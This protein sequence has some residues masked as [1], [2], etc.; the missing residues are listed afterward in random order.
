[1][2]DRQA[3]QDYLLWL[4]GFVCPISVRERYT[5][6]LSALTERSFTAKV[7]HDDNR[8]SD[9][10]NLRFRFAELNGIHP[11]FWIG[12]LP[13]ECLVLEM[14]IALSIRMEDEFLH[15]PELGN[16]TSVWFWEL[17]KNV[18]LDDQ[19]DLNY[20]EDY[21]QMRINIIV[22]RTYDHNGVGGLFP[23]KYHRGDMRRTE[24]W[25]QM[26]YYISEKLADG[27]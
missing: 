9:G 2:N 8:E 11:D 10:Q 16:R 20:D 18:G 14:L 21:V 27:S 12:I 3:V 25:Y 24:L 1:M 22:D 15:D 23:L 7:F 13:E 6:L 5:S 19:D 26:G 4:G 17:L